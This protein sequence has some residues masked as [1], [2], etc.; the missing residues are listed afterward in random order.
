ME[1][2][3][4][5]FNL[6]A[7]G[8]LF[9]GVV[10]GIAGGAMP[11]ISPSMTIALLL[12]IS[13]YMPYTA[14]ITLLMGAYQGA[15]FGGSISSIL[16][17]T[18]GTTSSAATAL[19]GY[20][21]TQQGKAGKA[22]RMA[23]YASCS[24]GLI[25]CII[26]LIGAQGLAKVTLKFGPPEY[27]GL[28]LM[29]LMLIAGISG[30][31]LVKGLISAGLGIAFSTVGIDLIYGAR[32]F[33]YGNINLMDGFSHL[34]IFIGLFAF[35]EVLIALSQK[36]GTLEAVQEVEK[37]GD[38]GLTFAEFWKEKLNILTSGVIGSFLGILPG[39]GG[40]TAGFLSYAE[41]QR[42]SKDPDSFGKGSLSG[43]AAPEAA[44]NAVCGGA[45]VPTLT[46]GIPG[47]V[48]TAILIGA[49][50][51]KGIKPGPLMFVEN[52]GEV[53]TIYIA[54]ALAVIT[55]AIVGTLG[56]PVFYH[57]VRIK[58]SIL[59]P[60]IVVICVIGTYA[61]RSNFFDSTAM[62]FFGVL[63][64]LLKKGKV[65]IPPIVIAFVIG[66]SL[67]SSMKQSLILSQGS[68]S[69]FFTP[70]HY[71]GI[72]H[73]RCVAGCIYGSSLVQQ[74]RGRLI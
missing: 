26:L 62:I 38:G 65:P 71:P 15:M 1:Y 33:T 55:L 43:I 4:Q 29:S 6:T 46:L 39:I 58:K 54:L 19:D 16:I 25:G 72:D 48:V 24:G 32:R 3:L 61:Y 49:L 74:G 70:S 47:D 52:I 18:P 73:H 10:V 27:F 11:G 64:Y 13:L 2:L 21:L 31:S 60:I 9:T 41:A 59:F 63:G 28:M 8:S 44:N 36:R 51:A 67:E 56:V 37:F 22:L 35:S 68:F 69:I 20:P 7:I 34:S 66:T 40:G 12:P 5:F 45:L 23:L 30:K 50:I 14:S 17:N 53:Y 57:V 42:R